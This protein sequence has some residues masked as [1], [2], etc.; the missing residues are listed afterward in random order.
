VTLHVQ[1][2]NANFVRVEGTFTYTLADQPAQILG[3]NSPR[4]LYTPSQW[5]FMVTSTVQGLPSER[6][7]N[8]LPGQTAEWCIGICL[9]ASSPLAMLTLR[10]G[11]GHRLSLAYHLATDSQAPPAPEAIGTFLQG[12]YEVDNSVPA[13]FFTTNALAE[14]PSPSLATLAP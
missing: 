3:G 6:M 1:G 2:T 11:A 9:L 8:D 7:A 12:G 10:D 13:V 5:E 14:I 4:T